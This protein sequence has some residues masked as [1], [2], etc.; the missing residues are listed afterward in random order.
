MA[1]GKPVVAAG[2]NGFLGLITGDNR[3]TA[4]ESNFM[5]FN[6]PPST[7]ENVAESVIKALGMT[8]DERAAL[9]M[10]NREFVKR[11]YSID[12][13]A[14]DTLSVY[15][16]VLNSPWPMPLGRRFNTG[17]VISGYY[18]YNNSGDDILL[19]S[20]ID[21][22][23]EYRHDLDI[24]VLSMRPKETRQQYGVNAVY[25]F[26]FLSVFIKLC[27]AKLL[28]TGGGTHM[29]DETSTQSLIYYLWVIN[30]ARALKI[31]NMLYANGIG[32]VN[33]PANVRRVRRALDRVDLITLREQESL[34]VLRNIGVTVPKTY[35]TSDAAFALP[36]ADY[37]KAAEFLTGIGITGP[38][39]CVAIRSWK[40]NPPGL[41]EHIA[42]FADHMVTNYGYQALFVPMQPASDLEISRRVISFMASPAVLMPE[43]NP[44]GDL[45]T[46]RGAMACAEIVLA[47]RLHALIYAM[48]NGVPMIGLVYSTKVRKLMDSVNQAWYMP[49]EETDADVLIGYADAIH[50]D[51]AAISEA[52]KEAGRAERE[53]ALLNARLC[54]ELLE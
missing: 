6:C 14:S 54:V 16:S 45:N 5:Y 38:F 32:P 18:G 21:N 46:V 27:G 39:F 48:E 9:G 44:G 26:N 36:P 41:E 2:N 15:D 4:A 23:S 34:T 24:T 52:I 22:L 50:S 53:K 47:M 33:R 10:E 17:V 7:V 30:T 20:I 40:N 31:K 11:N 37:K 42:A 51:K 3:Q 25:R 1:S 35:V 13:M 19:R 28:I 49:V 29:Q 8:D 43:V 12:R